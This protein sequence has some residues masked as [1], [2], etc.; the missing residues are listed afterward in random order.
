MESSVADQNSQTE[1]F[2]SAGITNKQ[3]IRLEM[4]GNFASSEAAMEGLIQTQLLP[5]FLALNLAESMPLRRIHPS[6]DSAKTSN[7]VLMERFFE[8]RNFR[9]HKQESSHVTCYQACKLFE[10]FII[11]LA[12]LLMQKVNVTAITVKSTSREL[13]EESFSN[14]PGTF[15]VQ[16]SFLS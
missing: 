13:N 15:S 12:F 10:I 14:C 2:V 7:Y 4:R 16:I 9:R 11:C 1:N 8:N 6:W 5:I 3:L